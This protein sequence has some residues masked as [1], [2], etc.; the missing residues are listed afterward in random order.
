MAYRN[1]DW[2]LKTHKNFSDKN[3]L[4]SA[5]EIYKKCNL[6]RELGAQRRRM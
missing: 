2:L 6:F 5:V 1:L 3:D 4:Y